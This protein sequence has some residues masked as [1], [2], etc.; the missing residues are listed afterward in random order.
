MIKYLIQRPVAVLMCFG[1]LVLAGC[2]LIWKIPV[3]LL[4]A[5]DVPLIVMRVHYPNNN[6]STIEQNVLKPIREHLANLHRIEKI[7]STAANHSGLVHL[8]F[9]HGTK[10]NLAYIEINE[11]LDRLANLLPRDM[12]RPQVMRINTSDIPVI[13]IQV[14]PR[15]GTDLFSLSLLTGKVLKK[16][17]EQLEGVSLVDINGRRQAAISITPD[18]EKLRALHVP[19]DLLAQTIQN[20]NQD[21]GGLSV[22][23]GQYR[24]FIKLGN[25]LS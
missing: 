23:D 10:M 12:Q 3:S 16:R 13:R 22:Q 4:P 5:V 20:A 25:S 11:K 7:E 17:I 8:T 21:I 1:A 19:A 14:M 24:Y 15:E 6:A 18:E 9:G 2:L